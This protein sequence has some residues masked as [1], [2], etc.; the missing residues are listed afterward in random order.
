M[1]TQL[2]RCWPTK[3]RWV[4]SSSMAP[5]SSPFLRASA[6]RSHM[7]CMNSSSRAMWS[8]Q[9]FHS[10]PFLSRFS[11]Y[12]ASTSSRASCMSRR[13]SEVWTLSKG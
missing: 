9:S 4:L 7:T 11:R 5:S 10:W 6:V 8:S 13:F 1:G 3:A 2:A 12:M